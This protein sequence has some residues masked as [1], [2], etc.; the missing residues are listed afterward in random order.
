MKTVWW[1]PWFNTVCAAGV[2]FPMIDDLA[3]GNFWSGTLGVVLFVGN[4]AFAYGGF[5]AI[6][7]VSA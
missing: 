2:L 7:R 3:A 1:Q 6:A 4:A 5:R